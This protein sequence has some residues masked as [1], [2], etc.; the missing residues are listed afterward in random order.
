MDRTQRPGPRD[1]DPET[2]TR[3]HTYHKLEP[4]D[5]PDPG[6]IHKPFGPISGRFVS[7]SPE[8]EGIGGGA[9]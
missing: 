7:L 4:L 9:S 1:P 6:P 5:G 8:D 2:Q 3:G